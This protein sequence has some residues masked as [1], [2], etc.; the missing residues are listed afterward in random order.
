MDGGLFVAD[1]DVTDAALLVDRVVQRQYRAA[2]IAE[3]HLDAEIG[4]RL[5]DDFSSGLVRA[6]ECGP[7]VEGAGISGGL[8]PGQPVCA[9]L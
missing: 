1:E 7:S 4:Q 5:D 2:R 3:N 8:L 9:Q 6:H